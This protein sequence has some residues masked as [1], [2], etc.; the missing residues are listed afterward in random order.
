MPSAIQAASGC[1]HSV[2]RGSRPAKGGDRKISAQS[3]PVSRAAWKTRLNTGHRVSGGS[4]PPRPGVTPATTFVPY[5]MQRWVWKLPSFPVI[6]CTRTRVSRRLGRSFEGAPDR[7]G[8]SSGA[9]YGRTSRLSHH[10]ASAITGSLHATS[11][12]VH[13]VAEALEHRGAPIDELIPRAH[14]PHSMRGSGPEPPASKA[15]TPAARAVP[16]RSARAARVILCQ[17]LPRIYTDTHARRALAR[18][19][20]ALERTSA[21]ERA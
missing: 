17:R 12:H 2:A 15:A 7:P 1:R 18:G 9:S 16:Y 13:G 20:R 5:S 19:Q 11:Q 14:A 21:S 3:A 4:P 10:G 8:R 6:P